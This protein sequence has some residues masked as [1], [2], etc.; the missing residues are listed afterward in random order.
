MRDSLPTSELEWD[1]RQAQLGRSNPDVRALL[2]RS[3]QKVTKIF[4]RHPPPHQDGMRFCECV[5]VCR[6]FPRTLLPSLA[7]PCV[8]GNSLQKPCRPRVEAGQ[9]PCDVLGDPAARETWRAGAGWGIRVPPDRRLGGARAA[10][11]LRSVAP[12]APHRGA[13][14]APCCDG[15]RT[16]LISRSVC[17]VGPGTWPSCSWSLHAAEAGI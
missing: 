13:P 1:L 9:R 3:R 12:A 10:P 16:L 7:A 8:S 11:L 14:V 2:A 15:W 4:D 6:L 5:C 17:Q